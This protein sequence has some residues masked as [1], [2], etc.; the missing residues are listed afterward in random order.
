MR[1]G[2]EKGEERRGER[3]RR[4]DG[5]G[6][7][8]VLVSLGSVPNPERPTRMRPALAPKENEFHLSI[9]IKE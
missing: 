3:M 1:D 5:E 2:R 4:G 6:I 9:T 7:S 8:I